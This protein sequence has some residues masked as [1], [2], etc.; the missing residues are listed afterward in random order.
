MSFKFSR[1]GGRGGIRREAGDVRL[2][3]GAELWLEVSAGELCVLLLQLLG[4]MLADKRLVGR[5]PAGR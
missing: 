5:A 4:S 2:D 1:D 3:D